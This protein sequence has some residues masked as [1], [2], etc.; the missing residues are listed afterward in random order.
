MRTALSFSQDLDCITPA[1]AAI[2]DLSAFECLQ[3]LVKFG[4]KEDDPNSI[5]HKSV[6]K[7]LLTSVLTAFHVS[8]LPDFPAVV[9]IFC[10]LFDHT[11]ILISQ[12]WAFDCQPSSSTASTEEPPLRSVLDHAAS[13]FPFDT[14]S[15]LKLLKALSGDPESARLAVEYFS[16]LPYY[17]HL[18]SPA[19]YRSN[20][21]DL[22]TSDNFRLRSSRPIRLPSL[23]IPPK[24]YAG[25]LSSDASSLTVRWRVDYSGWHVCLA[26]L[27]AYLSHINHSR[28]PPQNTPHIIA[29]LDFLHSVFSRDPSLVDPLLAHL[30]QS[31]HLT[32]PADLPARLIQ[33]FRLTAL[34]SAPPPLLL[35]SILNC[36]H[37]LALRD[38]H[39]LWVVVSTLSPHTLRQLLESVE[40]RLGHYPIT[41]AFLSLLRQILSTTLL[42]HPSARS[43]PLLPRPLPSSSVLSSQDFLP[44][45]TY[46]KTSLWSSYG[47]WRYVQLKQRWQI[48]TKILSLFYEVLSDS[49]EPNSTG[50]ALKQSLLNSLLY[51]SSFH[52]NLLSLIGVGPSAIASLIS[53]AHSEGQ[54]LES[55][56]LI[57]LSVL[58]KVL[59]HKPASAPLC[60][61]ENALLSLRVGVSSLDLAQVIASYVDYYPNPELVLPAARIFARLCSISAVVPRPGTPSIFQVLCPFFSFSLCSHTDVCAVSLLGYLGNRAESI[62]QAFLYRV[63]DRQENVVL[64]VPP[65]SVN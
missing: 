1:Q 42:A 31:P 23:V 65:L 34:S 54:S 56:V 21:E 43:S 4:L 17:Q 22:S 58:E 61:L 60:S 25:I 6:L 19:D 33:L 3:N 40:C 7:G 53:R 18:L 38:P 32:G 14:L 57:A 35:S 27:D 48:S 51:D 62:R 46:V 55:L 49:P 64:R 24:K 12:F 20:C 26:E 52:T 28:S 8:S 45:F 63:A 50:A 47:S 39:G 30:A 5:G 10:G 11:E 16:L 13:S 2:R 41:L 9:E 36:L 29:F 59:L 15:L 44:F 37:A